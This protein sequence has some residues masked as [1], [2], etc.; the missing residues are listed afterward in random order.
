[1]KHKLFLLFV[2][3]GMMVPQ[4]V[5]AYDFE[6]DGIYYK[7]SGS[8]AIVTRGNPL[9]DFY[10]GDVTIPSTVIHDGQT[11]IVTS[12]GEYAFSGCIVTSITLPSSLDSISYYAFSG[13]GLNSV[14]IPHGV[15]SIGDY[16]F[17]SCNLTSLDVPSSVTCIGDSAFVY[18]PLNTINVAEGN[19]RYDSRENCNAIIETATNCLVLGC[20]NT[21]IPRGVTSI[22]NG[23][24]WGVKLDSISIP[25]GVTSIGEKAFGWGPELSSITIPSSVT[26][27]GKE[28]F[29]WYLNGLTSITNL[30]TIPQTI[31]SST[32]RHYTKK[33]TLHVL[34]G[35]KD[36]Y[37]AKDYW[38]NFTIIDDILLPDSLV[39]D[40]T[41]TITAIPS[42]AN[43][44]KVT[45]A[46][47][48]KKGS[49]VTL[50]ATANE[51]YT[52]IK[53]SD[54]STENP[55][56]FTAAQDSTLTASFKAKFEYI[57]W[58]EDFSSYEADAVPVGGTYKYVCV[59]G[60][61]PTKIYAEALAGGSAPELLINKYDSKTHPDPG[62][63]SVTVPM[64]GKSGE[65]TLSFKRNNKSIAVT[66]IGATLGEMVRTGNTDEYPV[67]VA[68]GIKEVT[69]T[70]T[71]G[72]ANVR[73]D[74]I[75]LRQASGE[76]EEIKCDYTITAI[77]S[78][79]KAGVITGAGTYKEGSEVTLIATANEG[80]TFIKWSDGS[81]ANPY[82]FTATADKDVVAQFQ[83][84]SYNVT[85]TSADA[86]AG[87]VSG[88][89]TYN[90]GAQ[91][92][93]TAT[94]AVGYN[95]VA[96]SDGTTANPYLVTIKKDLSLT[97]SF[98]KNTYTVK[99]ISSD[100]T[101]GTVTGGASYE[102]GASITLTA[103][104]N[105]GY[106]FVNWSDGTTENPYVL[107]A[108]SNLS[109]AANFKI[110]SYAVLATSSDLTMGTV[111]GYGT[112]T[113]GSPVSLTATPKEGY[114]FTG[115]SDGT[116]TNPY[117]FTASKDVTVV[118]NFRIKTYE[119]SAVPANE[120]TG[121]TTGSDVYNHGALVTLTA[122]P[123]EGYDFIGWSD[124]T[125]ANP[126]H[127][128]ARNDLTLTANFQ[129]RKYMITAASADE[130]M[131]HVSG[132]GAE[133]AH[134]TVVTLTA[135]PNEG[136]TFQKW[137]D[138]STANPYTFTATETKTLAANFQIKS[139][140]ITGTSANTAMG[141][142][143]G[144][145][146]YTHG[147]E[148]TLTATPNE[149]YE[150]VKWHDGSTENPYTFTATADKE[151]T[152]TFQ[153]K[154]YTITATSAN[155]A[156][157]SVTGG[158]T[159][160]HGS[161][162]TLLATANE[163]CDFLQWSDGTTTNP[164]VFEALGDKTLMAIFKQGN[165][166]VTGVPNNESM[167]T[168]TGS[169][170]CEYGAEVTLTALPNEG[171]E[172]VNWSDGTT[173]NPYVIV[174]GGNKSLV[175]N[176]QLKQYAVTAVSA[177][178]IM[179][180]VTGSGTYGHGTEVTLTATPAYGYEF[181]R[182]SDGSTANP[183]TFTATADKELAAYFQEEQQAPE[184]D[185]DI[186]RLD[187]VIYLEP[188]SGACGQ[189]MTLS[190]KM[191]NSADI[192]GYQFDLYLPLG[193]SVATDEDGFPLA[194]MSI[195]RTTKAKTDYFG[196]DFQTSGAL[197][198]LCGSTKGYTF[199]GNDGE[200]CT[201]ALNISEGMAAGDY[202]V[203]LRAV[204]TTSNT[205]EGYD[206]DYLKSTLTVYDYTL[207]D[208]NNDGVVN[209]T[210]FTSTA[211]YILGHEPAVFVRKAADFNGDDVIN[212][213]DLMSLANYILSGGAAKTRAQN[214]AEVKRYAATAAD[215]YIYIEPV[216]VNAGGQTT[217]SVKMKNTEAIQGFQCD[218]YLPE[219]INF[220][221]D[222]DGF[223]LA[224][225]STAR[226]TT[227]KTDYFGFDIQTDGALRLLCGSTKG[228]TFSG[229]D[230]EIARVTID[231]PANIAAGTLPLVMR[232]L[233][234]T[235][236]SNVGYD[237]DL[238]ESTLTVKAP[239]ALTEVDFD[240][241]DPASL[242]ITPAAEVDDAVDITAPITKGAVTA[243]VDGGVEVTI[244]DDAYIL[245]IDRAGVLTLSTTAP[246][247]IVKVEFGDDADAYI[248]KLSATTGELDG[249]VWTGS[250]EEVVFEVADTRN[251]VADITTIK[252]WLEGGEAP[253][254]DLTF[255]DG[256]VYTATAA[257]TYG[258]VTYTRTFS[259]TDWQALYVPFSM[260]YD[261][262]SEKYDIAE[263]N[264]FVEYDDDDNGVYD[265]TFLV[266][267][268]KT[269]GC[270]EPNT[271]YLIRAKETGTH[272]LVLQDKTLEAAES[273]S[274]DCRSVKNEYTFTGTYTE[275]TDMY[276]NGYYAMSDGALKMPNAATVTLN[277]QRWYL[278][279]TSR[280]GVSSTKAQSIRIL[281]DGEEG[282]ETPSN[283]PEGGEP[284]AYDLMGR[285]VSV[286]DNARGV[287]IVNGKKLIK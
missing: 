285:M 58:Q 121:T 112:Y 262:W 182:W 211:N 173:A 221:K 177:N 57:I 203:I 36:V 141:S 213:T 13:T 168:V 286:K 94:P 178:N 146:T 186:S 220:A 49:Q 185:T 10:K 117:A 255:T 80:Y 100:E 98:Q 237:T 254:E 165:Y 84:N 53:W 156:M 170:Y 274:I 159:Y 142:V 161:E 247:K 229:T 39:T 172:F 88:G 78:D 147:S 218:I 50:S 256:E 236:S 125:M 33:L 89:G 61:G 28:A 67:M 132:G 248:D 27:I 72:S 163:G 34:K 76:S 91:V 56:T 212:V 194:E 41:C 199:S 227:S 150:F 280:T 265:R 162:V 164:Y 19:A 122:T 205:N 126:Y 216:T 263:I 102:H 202:P 40:T 207:G 119:I 208:L 258:K 201:I 3:I 166:A 206:T 273:N 22:G 87:T 20:K 196:C 180:S 225:M 217:L 275:V 5:S 16:A 92:S 138:G 6:V 145:N 130:T 224:E 252:V 157:G 107:T 74:D 69:F 108:S 17:E 8:N 127:F 48:Y 233:T 93:L 264:N 46:G 85:A 148:V 281:V 90:Y 113:H 83:I 38:N 14:T 160:A 116:T 279:V 276:A 154:S 242:G 249:F 209:I 4:M 135:T 7:K 153:K 193:V 268:K 45:G 118:G 270:T 47:T 21:N 25:E 79:A 284:V 103:V 43:A 231:V 245:E 210:D 158:G 179:G 259:N 140:T 101:M 232:N 63:F 243:T 246:G 260:D 18:C 198:V 65:M 66:A 134:G 37:A 219:G 105:E 267:L 32:F 73:L 136:Y 250:E 24:F 271:P 128:I 175:A 71:A 9:Q 115:W 30:A 239:Q 171:Y 120:G 68:A 197:R 96:W 240:F 187:N 251:A 278:A 42:D 287:N 261:E 244:D 189:Q 44:G 52:F 97:A 167:G 60:A 35:Y 77:P 106:E 81:T 188:A 282:I 31:S 241:T 133:Y 200:V 272:N 23:A 143:T 64:N 222:A 183:Y 144:G 59:D 204:T 29:Y 114:E 230:G 226:T 283:S 191:K 215:N 86:T 70:F 238:Y 104:P 54:G 192:Q 110:K 137:S 51:G 195:A 26:Y 75:S 181:E 109:L 62:S 129:I 139:Y 253:A 234:V 257:A 2:V 149:G 269:S 184:A 223:V 123:A 190:V 131:G 176:F 169:T 174:V 95:F 1:M 11:Y 111:E 124:G 228:Y 99:G 82:T 155:T 151:L 214:K 15:K 12:I 235:S 277:P 266:V 55:Y 152:A